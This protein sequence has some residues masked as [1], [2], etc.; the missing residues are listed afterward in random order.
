MADGPESTERET[1][2]EQPSGNVSSGGEAHEQDL[3]KRTR[4]CVLAALT[5]NGFVSNTFAG[6]ITLTVIPEPGTL[7]FL[8][9]GTGM[10]ACPTLRRR[11]CRR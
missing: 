1:S 8:L 7:A 4:G 11:F 3:G 2:G 6:Q 10:I 9:L 5:T